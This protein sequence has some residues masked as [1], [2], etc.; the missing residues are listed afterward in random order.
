[1]RGLAVRQRASEPGE[2]SLQRDTVGQVGLWIEEDLRSAHAGR[3]RAAEIGGREVVEVLVSAQYREAGVVQVQ[4]RLQVR[5]AV[6]GA[7]LTDVGGRQ[8]DPVS[9]S[10]ANQHLRLE[11]AFDVNVQ[12]C[13]W[14]H[15]WSA[16]RC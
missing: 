5:E 4:E 9:G 1:V 7:Q 2:H 8:S 3:R 15:P 13:R 6:A 12:L 10:K 14:Q 11:G 16:F